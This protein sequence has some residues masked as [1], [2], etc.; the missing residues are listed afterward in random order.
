MVMS[1]PGNQWGHLCMKQIGGKSQVLGGYVGS[2]GML[3]RT[4]L[5]QSTLDEKYLYER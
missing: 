2:Y 1:N 4:Q 3:L 5:L